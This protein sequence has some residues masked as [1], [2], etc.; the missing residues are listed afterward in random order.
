MRQTGIAPVAASLREMATLGACMPAAGMFA[1]LDAA[2]SLRRALGHCFATFDM[3]LTP[4]AAALPWPA[5]RTHPAKIDGRPVG[6]R[7]HA[8]FTAFANIAGLPAIAVPGPAAASG[9]PIGVQLVGDTGADVTL[10]AVA[11]QVEAARDWHGRWPNC[12][13]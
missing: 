7:G 9:L 5:T 1:A 12:E 13:R 4:A 3:I 6:P 10:L 2:T 11:A 8:V